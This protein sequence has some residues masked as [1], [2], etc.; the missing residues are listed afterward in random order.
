MLRFQTSEVFVMTLS[1]HFIGKKVNQ[2]KVSA[3]NGFRYLA[4]AE[5][6]HLTEH[7]ILTKTEVYTL[8]QIRSF[9]N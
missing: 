9:Y 6:Y 8:A 3:N 5:L 4:L 1:N 7:N 2:K